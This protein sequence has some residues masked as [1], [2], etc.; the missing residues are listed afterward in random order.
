[1]S[2]PTGTA[3]Q[4]AISGTT[5]FIVSALGIEPQALLW[6]LVGSTMGVSLAAPSSKGYAFALFIAATLTCALLGTAAADQWW[7]GAVF[8]RNVITVI[9]GAGFHP[10]F[11]AFIAAVPGIV[12]WVVDFAKRR[13]GGQP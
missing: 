7:K 6:A 4:I 10:M 8:A 13:I 5:A 2:D 12:Q 3:A 9:L 1:M 11:A